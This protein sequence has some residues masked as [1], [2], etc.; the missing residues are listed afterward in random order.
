MLINHKGAKDTKGRLGKAARLRPDAGTRRE[1]GGMPN[2]SLLSMNEQGVKMDK[3]LE[4]SLGSFS[5]I[6]NKSALHVSDEDHITD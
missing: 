6:C 2:I 4:I 1:L 3:R 5:M